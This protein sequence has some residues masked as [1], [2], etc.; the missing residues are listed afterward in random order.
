MAGDGVS[1]KEASKGST[2]W[3]L[4]VAGKYLE[5][6]QFSRSVGSWEE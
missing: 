5:K 2:T 1:R 4:T 3:G 6:K